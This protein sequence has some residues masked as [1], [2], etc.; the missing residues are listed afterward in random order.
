MGFLPST[1]NGRFVALFRTASTEM[2]CL[3][4]IIVAVLLSAVL[5]GA[6]GAGTA[7]AAVV[8]ARGGGTWIWVGTGAKNYSNHTQWVSYITVMTGSAGACPGKLEAWTS[9]FYVAQPVCGST[10]TTWYISRWIPSGNG[11]CGASLNRY[12]GRDIACIS[13]TV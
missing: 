3:R 11:V 4:A 5:A 1:M 8:Q 6:F 10:A 13:I 12:G 9:G 7:S 2:S